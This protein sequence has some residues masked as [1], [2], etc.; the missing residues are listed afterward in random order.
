MAEQSANV[1]TP[2]TAAAGANLTVR[3]AVIDLLRSLGLTTVF[4]NPGSTEL[5]MF[6][7]FPAEFRYVLGLQESIVIGM[8]D[9]FAQATRNAAL[10]NLHSAA[11]VGHA[12]GNIFTA[13]KNRTPLVITAGQQARSILPYEPFLFAAEAAELPK[14]YVKWSNEPARAEDVPAAIARAYHVAMQ[15][16]CGPTF[17]SIPVDDWDRAA[18]PVAPHA[19]SRALRPDPEAIAEAGAALDRARRPVFVVGAGVD[20]DGAWDE[21]VAL[22]ERHGA[23][24]WVSPMSSR[25]SFPESHPLFAGFLPASREKLV[26]CLDGHDVV[27]AVGAPVFTYHVEGFGPHVPPGADLYQIVDDPDM[28][29]WAPVGKSIVCS[30]RLGLDDLLERPARP[31][32]PAQQGRG[33]PPRVEPGERVTV[34]YLMQTLAELRPADSIVVE[35]SPSSRVTM[36]QYLRIDRP[37]SFYTTASGGL[38]H[39]LPA[40]VGVAMAR[41]RERRILG[42]FGD[43]SMMYS[44]QSLWSAAQMKLPMTIVVVN[45]S[46]YAALDQFAGHFGIDQPVGTRLPAIDFVGLAKSLGCEAARVERSEDLAPTLLR[47][48]GSAGPTLVDVA[49]A[50]STLKLHI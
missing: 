44:I 9:G 5:P 26:Q 42:L 13:Y 19:V 38:G 45:N 37:E 30:V 16:P 7:D 43:G 24:V 33:T 8:A 27:L 6:R 23:L 4:G 36:Q 18:E 50:A 2:K 25:C 31:E 41:G 21:I 46:G 40:A 48:F 15:P 14:P 1:D 22:A 34:P 11:G 29:A 3:E 32:R 17:V 49:V 35:E 28:A 10:V 12:M 47:A 20:R 39:S